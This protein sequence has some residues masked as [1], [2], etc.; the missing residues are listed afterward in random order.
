[1]Y[2]REKNAVPNPGLQGNSTDDPK[3]M[4]EHFN[5][6]FTKRRTISIS[7]INC[8]ISSIPTFLKIHKAFD[9]FDSKVALHKKNKLAKIFHPGIF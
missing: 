4:T 1:M 7:D 3:L 6:V 9:T 5:D 2:R 8:K